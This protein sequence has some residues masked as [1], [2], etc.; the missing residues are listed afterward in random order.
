MNE[1]AED[2]QEDLAGGGVF[3]RDFGRTDNL[4]N[5]VPIV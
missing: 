1:E 5:S 3:G 4:Y 2:E